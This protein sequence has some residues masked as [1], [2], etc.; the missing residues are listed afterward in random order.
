MFKI[1]RH[2]EVLGKVTYA[3]DA[4]YPDVIDMKDQKYHNEWIDDDMLHYKDFYYQYT[5][6]SDL[7]RHLDK[8][9]YEQDTDMVLCAMPYHRW[10]DIEK[11]KSMTAVP[12]LAMN[13]AHTFSKIPDNWEREQKAILLMAK[14]EKIA[15]GPLYCDAFLP[16]MEKQEA[17]LAAQLKTAVVY[18]VPVVLGA[19]EAWDHVLKVLNNTP[20]KPKTMIVLPDTLNREQAAA[21]L[22]EPTVHMAFSSLITSDKQ[23]ALRD[24]LYMTPIEKIVLSSHGLL[25]REEDTTFV[26][27]TRFMGK[28]IGYNARPIRKAISTNSQKLLED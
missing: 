5:G 22:K 2:Y 28:R 10:G 25:H 15:L 19:N 20:A 9:F 13:P 1:K 3:D 26:G 14:C 11:L 23:K 21:L 12:A 17:Q 24:V 4:N 27:T 16:D 18:G 8:M 6:L 7:S